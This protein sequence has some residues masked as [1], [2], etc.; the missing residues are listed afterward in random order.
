MS[1]VSVIITT[2]NRCESLKQT[3]ASLSNKQ[4][5]INLEDCEI[6]VVDNNSTDETKEFVTNLQENVSI[7]IRYL[8]EGQQGKSYALNTGIKVASG[9]II[10]F[11]DDDAIADSKWLTNIVTCFIDSDCDAVG[12]RVLPI[13]PA[14]TPAW[15]KKHY[16][17]LAGPIVCHD[18][19]ENTLE[20]DKRTMQPFVGANIAIKKSCFEEL[21]LFRTDLGP[22]TGT[23]GDDS[24][25]F[26][27]LKT[28]NKKVIYCGNTLVYHKSDKAR[29]T[30]VYFAK[31]WI[32]EGR[33]RAVIYYDKT[34]PM[35]RIFGFP[36]YLLLEIF[37]SAWACLI[38]L[39]NREEFLKCWFQLYLQIG[40]GYEY[41]HLYQESGY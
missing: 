7:S 9:D 24:E 31:W 4:E 30:Y 5:D 18:Y 33:Y 29:M 37:K 15:I 39:G 10:A 41:R 1:K 13:Y 6:L 16:M 36:R 17:L 14:N 35:K 28:A 38:N 27:R 20:Y 26:T 22:G 40:K 11:I 19:G 25:V 2:H 12:G 8:F 32:R 23:F 34:K 3:L 21:G